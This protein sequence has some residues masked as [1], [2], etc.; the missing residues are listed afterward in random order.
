[1]KRME[2]WLGLRDIASI[3]LASL[4]FIAHYP[5]QTNSK[6]KSELKVNSSRK[7]WRFPI[8]SKGPS[9]QDV[10]SSSRGGGQGAER[11][12]SGDDVR[13]IEAKKKKEEKEKASR[14]AAEL[15]AKKEAEKRAAE[16]KSTDIDVR[17][18]GHSGGKKVDVRQQGSSGEQK[19]SQDPAPEAEIPSPGSSD[20]SSSELKEKVIEDLSSPADTSPLAAIKFNENGGFSF[21]LNTSQLREIINKLPGPSQ[22]VISIERVSNSSG[23]INVEISNE[24]KTFSWQLTVKKDGTPPFD[25]GGK[26]NC[27]RKQ[28][29]IQSSE[30]IQ[31]LGSIKFL[32]LINEGFRGPPA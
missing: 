28:N 1:M 25:V 2:Q 5:L 14:K 22:L 17:S 13:V 3:E 26:P 29:G 4:P 7:S 20:G 11:A 6:K 19:K 16:K 21:V 15:A 24:D 23:M 9:E 18:S 8:K 31:I 10:R 12:R 32:K 27:T 30:L